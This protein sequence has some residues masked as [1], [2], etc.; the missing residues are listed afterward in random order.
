MQMIYYFTE[1]S[2]LIMIR[3]DLNSLVEWSIV[4]LMSFDPTKCVHLKISNKQCIKYYINQHQI[5]QSTHATYLG[6]TIDEHL[7][8]T[9]HVDKIVAKANAF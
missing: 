9:N 6:V 3:E 5:E 1:Q 4:W 2:T 8:W 7:K